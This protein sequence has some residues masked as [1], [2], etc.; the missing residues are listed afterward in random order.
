MP[1]ELLHRKL[2]YYLQG[3]GFQIHTTLGG[4]HAEQDYENALV[5]ALEIDNVAYARQPVY[6]VQYRGRQVGEYRP[7]LVAADG[8]VLLE[9]K[10]TP[11]IEPLHIA[12]TLSYLAVTGAEL[13]LIMN[14]GGSSMQFRRVPNFLQQ[15]QPVVG[16]IVYPKNLL[17]P[18]LT[19]VILDSLFDV[20]RTLGAGFLH[21]VY[22]RT[23]RIEMLERGLTVKLIK[24]LPLRFRGSVL[25]MKPVRLL[26]IDGKVLVATV[27]LKSV[28]SAQTEKLRWAMRN[29]GVELG[30]IANFYPSTLAFRFYRQNR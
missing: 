28:K 6:R 30:L 4:G 16:S 23:A 29:M 18:E 1:T 14:F 22:R 13:G 11:R 27:A 8:R 25:A 17:Y 10:A 20:H 26:L 2:V 9:L 19:R 15:R 24:E 21:Q 12:Q 7:D 5:H 3:L